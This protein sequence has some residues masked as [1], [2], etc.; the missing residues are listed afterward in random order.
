MG[1]KSTH[2]DMQTSPI[3]ANINALSKFLNWHNL[4]EILKILK[5]PLKIPRYP[6]RVATLF[7]E[8][9]F[10]NY[11]DR[12]HGNCKRAR[13]EENVKAVDELVLVQEDEP[14]SY[15]LLF[16]SSVAKGRNR[17]PPVPHPAPALLGHGIHAVPSFL[18]GEG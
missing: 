18:D 9:V 2:A 4:Q 16:S 5:P 17:C 11:T 1:K 12:K 7:C 10:H 13:T 6:K 14:Q 8:I 15:Q 3:F